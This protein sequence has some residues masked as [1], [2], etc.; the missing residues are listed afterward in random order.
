MTQ[1][2]G[3]VMTKNDTWCHVEIPSDD[4]KKSEQ[5]YSDVFGWKFQ[6]VPQ[7]D[8][9]LYTTPEGIGGGIMKRPEGMPPGLIN[10]INVADIGPYL[11][12]IESGGGSVIRPVTEIPG[13]G[14]FALVADPD[15][16]SF[17]LWKQNPAELG[18]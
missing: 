15:G 5:F 1:Q 6:N 11:T 12:R 16:N 8:Y 9:T 7:M 10:Y 17:G 18:R 13:V 3:A 2:E 14:W 4:T